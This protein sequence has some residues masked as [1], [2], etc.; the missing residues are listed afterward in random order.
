MAPRKA[1]DAIQLQRLLARG[2]IVM[3]VWEGMI[4]EAALAGYLYSFLDKTLDEA[5]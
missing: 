5:A 2:Y 4:Y 1:K 3:D